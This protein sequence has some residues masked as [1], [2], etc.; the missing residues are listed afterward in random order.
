MVKDKFIYIYI[1]LVIFVWLFFVNYTFKL[2]MYIAHTVPGRYTLKPLSLVLYLEE[3]QDSCIQTDAANVS[4]LV[5]FINILNKEINVYYTCTYFQLWLKLL[6]SVRCV[7]VK[8]G[9]IVELEVRVKF[10]PPGRY[11]LIYLP[12]INK[13]YRLFGFQ[14]CLL[15]ERKNESGVI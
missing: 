13:T 14:A 12:F 10:F 9:I 11:F 8:N 15:C 1:Y 3:E 2:S 4:R 5:N 6:H 7:Q